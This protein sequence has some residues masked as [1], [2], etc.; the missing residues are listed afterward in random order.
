MKHF[1][2]YILIRNVGSQTDETT[3]EKLIRLVKENSEI[4]HVY[5]TASHNE[6][7][8]LVKVKKK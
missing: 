7:L 2:N 5:C 8:D 4:E 6:A 3:A 1:Y